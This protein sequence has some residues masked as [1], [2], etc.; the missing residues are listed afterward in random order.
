MDFK[1]DLEL[2][3]QAMDNAYLFVTGRM[4]MDD[5][6]NAMDR[7]VEKFSLPFDPIKHDG[8]SDDIIDML[9]EHFINTEE[10]EKCTELTKLKDKVKDEL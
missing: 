1:E 6:Y 9:I 10:Y 8:K 3:N 5:I 7:G 2:F 4:N